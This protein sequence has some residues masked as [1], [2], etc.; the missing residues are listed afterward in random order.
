MWGLGT[1]LG[2]VIGGAF[3]G[4]RLGWRW[5]FFI[6]LPIGGL[7]APVLV[8]LIPTFDARKGMPYRD[9]IK[10]IDWIGSTLLAATIVSLMLALIFGGNEFAWSD[11][12]IIGLFV[13]SGNLPGRSPMLTSK[14]FS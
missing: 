11:G 10:E 12:R 9:R 7:I 2:P 3:S 14:A 1:L 6:N 8:F 13:L 4:S 5:A